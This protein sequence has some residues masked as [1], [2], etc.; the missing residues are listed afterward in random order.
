MS[1]NGTNTH[2]VHPDVT[3]QGQGTTSAEFLP[4]MD[5]LTPPESNNE[6]NQIEGHSQKKKKLFW[7][8]KDVKIIKEF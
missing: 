5:D 1:S 8:F 7:F 4:E 2:H 3:G 6:E